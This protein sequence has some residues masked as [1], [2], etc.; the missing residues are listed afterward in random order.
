MRRLMDYCRGYFEARRN[1]HHDDA[2]DIAI[3]NLHT[4]PRV[5]LLTFILL[6]IFLLATP[7]I[8]PD[9]TP[10]VWHLVFLPVSLSMFVLT[11]L[12]ARG[13]EN[14]AVS[15]RASTA[16]C[17]IYEVALFAGVAAID[18]LG[19]LDAP[20][21]FLPMLFVVMPVLFNLPFLVMYT[22]I[23]LAAVSF[24]V[25]VLLIKPLSIGLYDIFEAIVAVFF[26]LAVDYLV[27]TLRIRDYETRMKY[28]LLSTRDAF[29]SVFN[30]RASEDAMRKYLRA[31]NPVA[32]CALV[33]LDLDDFKKINDTAGHMVG[34]VVLRRTADMLLRI[35]RASDIVGRF[36]GDEFIILAKGMNSRDSIKRKC[37]KIREELWNLME[38]ESG[39]RV[40]CSIGAVLISGQEVGY[41]E[42]F[43]Q[44][45]A[46]L[47][48]AKKLGKDKCV[49]HQYTHKE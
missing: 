23:C 24:I 48:E 43:H 25:L 8:I 42:V 44:A 34:D 39:L 32:K 18:V 16:L 19:T 14:A 37:H 26:S 29:S 35:F 38:R 40:T 22:L 41:D 36:G 7:Y 17:I 33:I 6:A 45:D 9:W 15:I 47:Y 28:K 4:L 31:S 49:I 13:K 12:Y 46:A 2:Q 11:A 1:Y 21:S 3:N 30:K 27:T 5:A 10:S 20:A